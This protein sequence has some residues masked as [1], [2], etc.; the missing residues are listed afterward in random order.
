MIVP[1]II[2]VV[3]LSAGFLLIWRVPVCPPA[4]AY[5]APGLSIVIPARNEERNLARLLASLP[6]AGAPPLEVLVVDD[7]S[8]DETAA[9]AEA[10]G[11]KVVRSQP[12][13]P[14]WTG[15]AWACQQ[16]AERSS[17][18]TLLFLDAD[19]YLQPG[20]L[21]RTLSLWSRYRDSRLVFSILPYHET[22]A[23]YEQL[24][25][26]FNILMAAGAG[27]FGVRALPRLFGQSLLI[28]KSMYF[29]AGGHS[30]VRDFILE[31]L[32]FASRIQEAGGRILCFGGRGTMHMR[33]FPDGMRQMSESW[34][35]AFVQG[36]AA[37]GHGV[38][39]YSIV[40]I[41]ALWSVVLL[42]GLDVANRG[43][44]LMIYLLLALQ[45]AWL[46]RQFGSY[47]P[48]TCLIYPVPLSYYC[49]VFSRS[50]LRRMLKQKSV[51]RGREV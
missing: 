45:L 4:C 51:W 6:A 44:L 38:V 15:K 25:L 35:K 5:D 3:G 49:A 7:E 30:A 46:A 32:R 36:A 23:E 10:L 21:D 22:T 8:T 41:S 14:G 28:D 47:R 20:G 13:P 34:A 37:S 27:G 19:T 39:M 48:L 12:L 50:A 17:G 18:S 11:A 31:N 43:A 24:S 9:I 40:W 2:A 33:M 1:L 16:G 26:V 42:I 29:A